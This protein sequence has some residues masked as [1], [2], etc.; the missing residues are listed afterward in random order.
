MELKIDRGTLRKIKTQ[1]FFIGFKQTIVTFLISVF[2]IPTSVEVYF[3]LFTNY[4]IYLSYK[5]LH[6]YVLLHH[7][8]GGGACVCVCVCVLGGGG[9]RNDTVILA[10]LRLMHIGSRSEIIVF[11]HH[12]HNNI[13]S[14]LIHLE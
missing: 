3:L 5:Q 8:F 7:G 2:G 6:N 14:R 9:V 12:N 1:P 11:R 10:D 13:N 4:N